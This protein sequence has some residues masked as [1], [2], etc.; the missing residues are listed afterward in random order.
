MLT[1]DLDLVSVLNNRSTSYFLLL[2]FA[3]NS[4]TVG[5]TNAPRDVTHDG[6]TYSAS[7]G[8]KSLTP[9]K[10]EAGVSRDIFGVNLT[11]VDF[12]FRDLLDSE[13]TG[14]PVE[15]ISRFETTAGD[16]DLKIYT[17]TV[18]SFSTEI[19][20]DEHLISVQ[21]VGPITKLQQVTNRVTTDASQQAAH[22]GDT[23]MS[24]S[25]DTENEAEI[26][27]GGNS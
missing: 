5:V 18:S 11:D 4:G 26:K 15:V 21:C 13:P 24:K 14:V 8:L 16:R 9:P 22:P 27:W 19:E 1:L 2:K 3:F 6:L 10:A 23:S 17:G 7:G 20:S 25:F 12:A